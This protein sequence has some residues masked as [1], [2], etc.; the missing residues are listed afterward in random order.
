ASARLTVVAAPSASTA[1]S[2]A[3]DQRGSSAQAAAPTA[4][5]SAAGPGNVPAPQ[6][7]A[8]QGSTALAGRILDTERR[9]LPGVTIVM[10]LGTR[11]LRAVT[12]A[13]GHFRLEDPP[14][15]DQLILVDGETASTAS[16]KY[17]TIPV[18]V[19]IRPHGVTQ[20]HYVPP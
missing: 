13:T 4:S 15:G 6:G 7:S 3:T 10:P 20:L 18:T 1:L 9:P 17:P 11:E 19:K 2:Q 16:A 8:S 5:A 14:A 12:D